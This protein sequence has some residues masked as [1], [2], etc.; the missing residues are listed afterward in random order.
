[1]SV[2]IKFEDVSKKFDMHYQRARSFQELFVGFFQKNKIDKQLEEIWALRSVNFEIQQGETIAFIGPNGTGK[3]TTLKLI[4]GILF[5]TAGKIEINGRVG[6]LLELGAGFHP[7]LTGRENIHLNGS[8]LGLSGAEIKRKFNEIVAFSELEQFI[9]MPVKHYSSGM[10]MRLGFSIAVHTDPD[11]LLVD[12]VLAVGDVSFQRKCLDRI[13]QLRQKG[14]TILLVS[15]G[16]DTVRQICQR[17]I[18]M[19]KGVVVADGFTESVINRYLED[20]YNK[21]VSNSVSGTEQRW[22]SGEIKIEQVRILDKNREDQSVFSVGDSLMIEIHYGTNSKIEKPV[23]G[24]AF[25]RS[26]G[27][28]VSGPNTRFMGY[29]IPYLEA[30]GVIIYNIPSL[31]LL[32]GCY[33]LSLSLHNW[34]DT[35]MFDYHEQSYS[36]QVVS[37]GGERYGVVSLQGEW[38]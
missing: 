19:E 37:N 35:K 15:H 5:P 16:L 10:Y 17:A 2:V 31:S 13:D 14:V 26:D 4:S 9:D 7:D 34:N 36:F 21:R 22:G 18:W 27:L 6:G 30:D 12:E 23:F 20:T 25:H 28:L 8:I 38:S 1:M 32:E 33:L 24:L 3:S 11:I 29:D